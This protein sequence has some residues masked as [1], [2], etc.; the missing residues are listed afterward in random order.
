MGFLSAIDGNMAG[1]R[2]YRHPP[3][4]YLSWIHATVTG[5]DAH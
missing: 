4:A 1:V 3:M 2:G 5:H